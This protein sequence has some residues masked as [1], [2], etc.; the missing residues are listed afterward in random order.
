MTKRELREWVRNITD[1]VQSDYDPYDSLIELF[2][3]LGLGEEFDR[4]WQFGVFDAWTL[5][6]T[7]RD[8]LRLV[9][10]VERGMF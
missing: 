5:A 4:A 1:A 2:D 9:E 7:Q 3:E 6:P 8:L 10:V